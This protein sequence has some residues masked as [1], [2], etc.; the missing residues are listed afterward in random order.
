M[1]C[2]RRRALQV[3][4]GAGGG[5]V[6]EGGGLGRKKPLAIDAVLNCS[7]GGPGEDGALQGL[8]DLA[9]IRYTGPTVAGAALGMDKLVFA[10]AVASAGLAHLPCVLASADRPQPFEGPFI[11]KPRFGGSSIGIETIADWASVQ[12]FL[13]SP[14]PLMRAGAV[15][16]PFRDGAYDLNIAIRTWP[17][18]QLSAIEKPTRDGNS[19]AAILDYK[20]KYVGAEGMATAP[21]E[22]PADIP[23]E[24]AQ[25]IRD[26]AREVAALAMVRGVARLDFLAA[27]DELFINELNTIPGS[28]AK[29]L[30]IDPPLP[31][32]TLLTDLLDE[33]MAG[34][35]RQFITT[36]ADGT[37]LRSA[38]SISNKLG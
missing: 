22:L 10:A 4:A 5:F 33:A 34:P 9:G 30:W 6:S 37:V 8:F 12:A 2:P 13:K 36:G 29:H 28:L 35:A 14:Q 20:S 15:V 11:V 17:E 3:V 32:A 38:G 19:A 1:G 21:R 24:W 25:V 16:E 23:E 26:S 18:L 7:H 27:G 31:F